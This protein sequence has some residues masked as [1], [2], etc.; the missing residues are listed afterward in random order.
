MH[1]I[2]YSSMS[3][4]HANNVKDMISR[5]EMMVLSGSDLPLKVVRS[6]ISSALDIIVHLTRFQ[7]RRRGVYEIS[8]VVGME[9]DEILL[10]PLFQY[11]GNKQNSLMR[12]TFPLYR[13]EKLNLSG[14][15]LL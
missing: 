10:E 3:T 5:L 4:G 1:F 8:Q 9:N 7:D 2:K 13:T 6:Q 12:T 15:S 14:L 11:E